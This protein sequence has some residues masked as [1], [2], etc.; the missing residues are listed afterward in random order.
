MPN[1]VVDGGVLR[2]TASAL[3]GWGVSVA[4]TPPA[5]APP[6]PAQNTLGNYLDVPLVGTAANITEDGTKAV[7]WADVVTAMAG[8]V[9]AYHSTTAGLWTN[10]ITGAG[11]LDGTVSGATPPP[12]GSPITLTPNTVSTKMINVAAGVLLDNATGA[13]THTP[14]VPTFI[15]F[16]ALPA[17]PPG[18]AD[19]LLILLGTWAI[20]D[21]GQVGPSLV[22][23]S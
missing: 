18:I 10:T 1:V 2:L 16:T 14:I 19:T 23:T 11:G 5:P 13:F 7:L 3:W 21:H 4:G 22:A 20:Q 8:V 12:A 6:P 17:G 15:A 9:N